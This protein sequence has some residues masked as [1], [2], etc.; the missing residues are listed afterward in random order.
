MTTTTATIDDATLPPGSEYGAIWTAYGSFA[1]A[2]LMYWPA[3]IGLIICYVRRGGLQ[4][5]FIDSHYRW[6]TRVF[7]WST[8]IGALC[9][10]IILVGVWS[11]VGP[12]LITAIQSGG[13]VDGLSFDMSL[14]NL[15]GLAAGALVGGLGLA[16][17]WLAFVICVI[18][19]MVRLA[20]SQSA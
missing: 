12:A 18:R 9:V 13:N 1:L 20:N 2:A 7:W 10:T 15:A 11:L 3:L 14:A 6:L 5:G 17:V 19:G 8:L 4:A 16:T